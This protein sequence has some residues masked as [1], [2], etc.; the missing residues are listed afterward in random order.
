MKYNS[1]SN[2]ASDFKSDERVARDWFETK[3]TITPKLYDTEVLLPINCVNN[4]MWE[5]F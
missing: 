2:R 3:S 1:G 5:S 4:K